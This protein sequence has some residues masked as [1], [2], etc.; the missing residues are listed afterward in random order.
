MTSNL[1]MMKAPMKRNHAPS[2]RQFVRTFAMGSV[3]TLVGAPWVGTLVAT[4][5]VEDRAC[6]ATNGQMSI[7]VS[8]FPALL[9]EFGSVRI[10]V[11]PI[12]GSSPVGSFYPVIITRGTGDSFFAVSSSCTHRGCIV[13]AFNG[14]TISCPCHGSEFA[15]DGTVTKGPAGSNLTRYQLSYDGLDTLKIT[16][17]GLGYSITR[18]TLEAGAGPRVRL[19]FPTFNQVGYEVRFR[20][21]A[22]GPWTVV[23]FALTLGGPANNTVITGDGN[24]KAVFAERTTATGF[25]AIAIVVKEV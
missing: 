1:Q 6:A 2:R 3:T 16:V 18:Y 21:T 22:G 10:S 20:E 14:D 4:L 13:A 24:T 7:Q 12:D 17:P 5:L 19:E 23:P 15:M 25:Y 8:N 9:Q 11:N